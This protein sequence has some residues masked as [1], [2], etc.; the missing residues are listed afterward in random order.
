MSN[1]YYDLIVEYWK[2]PA[3]EDQCFVRLSYRGY[4]S[5]VSREGIPA[6]S[7]SEYSYAIIPKLYGLLS[8][9]AL[10]ASG[11]LSIQQSSLQLNGRGIMIGF[12]DTGIDYRNPA[13]MYPDGSTRIAAIWD[14]TIQTGEMPEGLP[15]G[16]EYSRGMINQALAARNP[17]DIVPSRDTSG[18]GTALAQ[19]AAGSFAE[20]SDYCGAAPESTIIVVKCK[21]AK[22]YLKDFYMVDQDVFAISETDVMTGVHYLNAMAVKNNMPLVIC[23]GLGTNQGDHN[24]RSSLAQFL[25][26]IALDNIRTV[27]VAGGNEGNARHHFEGGGQYS[28]AEIRVGEHESGFFLE[29][30]GSAPDI[31]SVS[32]RSPSGEIV[33]RI[34]ARLGASSEVSFLYDQTKVD[35]DYRLVERETGGELIAMRFKNPSPG[36]WS[37]GVYGSESNQGNYHMWLPLTGFIQEDTYFLQ[38]SPNVTLTEP[39]NAFAP[40]TV[41]GYDEITGGIYINSSRGFSRDGALKPDLSAPAVNIRTNAGI[42]SGTSMAAAITAG[43]AADFLEWAVVLGNAPVVNSD[44][45]KNYFKRGAVRGTGTVYPNQQEGYGKLNLKGVFDSLTQS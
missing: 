25:N 24:G 9:E 13:F 22:P 18:H 2:A 28:E 8:C 38:S 7:V 16:S 35:V 1:D 42:Y 37:I 45:V 14:Q 11:I 31:F 21:E 43:A 33:P 6:L 36:I 19:L 34:P 10:S 15:Y 20:G 27:V 40:I 29:L 3:G 17:Y 4:I 41:S 39:A 26:I 5:Y 30:W 32:F 12:I 44:D 23:L